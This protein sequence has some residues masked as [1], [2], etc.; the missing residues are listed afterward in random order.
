MTARSILW[1]AMLVAGIG[2]FSPPKARAYR[3][4]DGTDG[5]VADFGEFELELA[6]AEWV[7]ENTRNY[8]LS[9]ATVLNLGI[10]PRVELVIDFVGIAPTTPQAGE[11]TY[12]VRDTDVFLKVL[13]RKGALQEE[14]GPSIALEGGVLTPELHGEK[15]FGASA[16]LIV[17]VQWDWVIFH[18]NNEAQLSRSALEFGWSNSLIT[19]FRVSDKIWPVTELLWQPKINSSERIYSALAGGIWSVSEEVALDAAAVVAS[20][21]SE[22]EFEARLGLT[23]AVGLWSKPETT[24]VVPENPDAESPA[25]NK[26]LR[27]LALRRLQ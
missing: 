19:E 23:W 2:L 25:A 9:P 24:P 21:D 11:A 3:P 22:P 26:A 15:G 10:F 14:D 17:S 18:L 12:Q 5:D 13:L 4:F 6:P 1:F 20:I 7:R 16:D 27:T 8:L